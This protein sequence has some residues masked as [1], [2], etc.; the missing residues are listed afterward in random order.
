MYR[1]CSGTCL[2]HMLGAGIEGTNFAAAVPDDKHAS[3]QPHMRKE[4][5]HRL[6]CPIG[7]QAHHLMCYMVIQC[8]GWTCLETMLHKP[9]LSV[10]QSCQLS[11]MIRMQH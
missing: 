7:A 9:A 3:A 4:P 2:G 11:L 1:A 6:M 5:G 8:Q 10:C